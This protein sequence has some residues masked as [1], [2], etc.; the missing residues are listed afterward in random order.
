[1][2]LEKKSSPYRGVSW[3]PRR[4]A[5]CARIQVNGCRMVLGY[6]DS[7]LDAAKKFNENAEKFGSRVRNALPLE[8]VAA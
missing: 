5:W 4:K 8:T 2:Q 3:C 7:S 6:F 1:M